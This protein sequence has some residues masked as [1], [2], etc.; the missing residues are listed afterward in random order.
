[1]K[2]PCVHCPYCEKIIPRNKYLFK[3][4]YGKLTRPNCGKV[5]IIERTHCLVYVFIP[6][7]LMALAIA[8]KSIFSL[9]F[10]AMTL[11]LVVMFI[12]A[13]VFGAS[14]T[15]VLTGSDKPDFQTHLRNFVDP[16]NPHR[17]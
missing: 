3:M 12:P 8:M 7:A 15:T 6:P 2:F 14:Y 4:L 13:W 10:P 1:M 16:R 11:A 17:N 9:S 5:S